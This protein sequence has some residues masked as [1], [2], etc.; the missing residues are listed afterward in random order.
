V[1]LRLRDDTHRVVCEDLHR[2]GS[3]PIEG[4]EP[5]SSKQR[6]GGD[7][8]A[9][10]QWSDEL[11][12]G[13]RELDAQHQRLIQMINELNDAMLQG[14]GKDALSEVIAGL[15]QYARTHFASEEKLF[16]EH[17]YPD[18]E[19]HKNE[20]DYFVGKVDEFKSELEQGR[21][22]LS[23]KVAQFLSG[24]LQ[25]HIKVVD[26]QYSQFFNERGVK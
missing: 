22:G 20:H 12:V 16:A 4:F 6:G 2:L 13:V 3:A 18:A 5:C 15:H 25:N 23:I 17:G 14:K 7:A 8:M 21:L 19:K 24:W 1:V 26:K 10:I 9:L 11:S